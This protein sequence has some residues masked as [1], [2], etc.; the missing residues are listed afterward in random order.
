MTMP[1]QRLILASSSPY[2]R[3]LLDRLAV[4]YVCISPDIDESPLPGEAPESTAL[5]LAQAKAEK[6]AADCSDALII[7]SDQVAVLDGKPISKPGDH[8]GATAQLRAMSGRI[9][10][11][12]TAICL[13]DAGT[14]RSQTRVVPTRVRLR[15]L[16]DAEIERYLRRDRPYDCAGSA[17]I[18]ALGI[19]LVETV[20]SEDPT[21]LIG[22]PLIA[23][24]DMLRRA[25]LQL[26]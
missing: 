24:C 8:A 4:T 18:E 10:V 20:E 5:R 14:G 22:L 16:D 26:P 3:Q 25:G 19:A 1:S 15:S 17:K 12:H 7:G 23:L 2:R 9:T 11:F 13:L 21:A 6:I